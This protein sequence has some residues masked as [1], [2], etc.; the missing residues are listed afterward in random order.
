MQIPKGNLHQL[1]GLDYDRFADPDFYMN[2]HYFI[3]Q[4]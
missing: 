2:L 3:G 1:M 4:A